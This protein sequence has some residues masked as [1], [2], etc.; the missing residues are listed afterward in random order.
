MIPKKDV[1]LDF[2]AE[3]SG[4]FEFAVSN[5]RFNSF[6]AAPVLEHLRAVEPVL[7]MIP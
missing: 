2:V 5:G 7:D 4:A 6:A 3:A 1:A